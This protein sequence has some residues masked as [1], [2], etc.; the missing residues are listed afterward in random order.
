VTG[1]QGGIIPVKPSQPGAT[2]RPIDFFLEHGALFALSNAEKQLRPAG[3]HTDASGQT[4]TTYHQVHDGVP[5][6]AGVLKVHQDPAGRFIAAN[7]DAFRVPAKLSVRPTLPAAQAEAIARARFALPGLVLEQSELVVVDPGWYGDPS[8]G[9]H[10]AY[11]VVLRDAPGS[12]REAFFIDAHSG[13]MLDRWN[14]LHTARLREVHDAAGSNTLPGPLARAEGDYPTGIADVNKAYDHAGDTY[15]YFLR[16]FDRD[17][18]D[19]EGLPLVITVRSTALPCPNAAWNGQQMVFCSG[20]VTDDIMAHEL[21]HGVTE[22]TANLIYQNQSGQLNEAISDIFGELVDLFNGDAAFPGPPAGP[23]YWPSHPT[24][25]GTDTPNNPRT[26]CSTGATA[27]AD[28]YRWLI[29]EDCSAGVFR[30]MWNPVCYNSPDRANSPLQTCAASDSGG[31]HSG[32]GVANHAFAIMTDGKSFNGQ[33]VTGIGPIKAG[34]VW[35]RALTTYLTVAS[36]FQD[37]YAALNQAAADLVGTDPNDPRTGLPSGDPFTASDAEQVDKALV[38][39][40]M[41]TEGRCGASMAVLDST[42]P[43]QCGPPRTIIFADDFENGSAGWTVSNSNPPTPYDWVQ[44]TEPLPFGRAGTGWF[45]ADAKVGDCMGQ[46]ESAVHT[47]TSPSIALPAGVNHPTVAFTHYIASEPGYDGGNV[48]ISVDN[49]P[50]Q[51]VA[52]SAFEYN[53]YNTSLQSVLAGNTNPLAGEPAWTGAGGEWGTSLISLKSFASGGQAVRLR[54]EFGKDG[55]TG[56]DGWYLDDFEV[57][58]CPPEPPTAFDTSVGTLPDTPITITLAAQDEGQPDPPGQL[59]FIVTSLP[60]HGTLSRTGGAPIESVP[61][62]LPLGENQVVYQPDP[63]YEGND[64]FRFKADDG[65]IPPE[66]G[67]SGEATVTVTVGGPRYLTELFA[68][69]ADA[70]DLD[71][72][73]LMLTPDGSPSFY[74]ACLEPIT[75]LPTDPAGGGPPSFLFE[76]GSDLFFVA[77]GKSV[78]LYGQN[79]SMFWFSSNGFITFDTFDIDDLGMWEESLAGHFGNKRIAALFDDLSPPSG[80]TWSWKELSDRIAITWEN[81]PEYGTSNSNTFQVELYFDGRIQIAWLNI[82][83]RDGLVGLSRGDGLPAEFL[84]QDLSSLRDCRLPQP[85]DFDGD[86]DVDADDYMLFEAC[87]SGPDIPYAGDCSSADFDTDNDVDQSDF[88]VFQ[89]CLSGENNPG[90]PNCAD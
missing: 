15:D 24:G 50:W 68:G 18:L 34:A 16:A 70:F 85:A 26:T 69:P 11:H 40:E 80:G 29:G 25:P 7:G 10:L 38:A 64:S 13:R 84:E 36:D 49:G 44:T 75:E 67:E 77:G 74:D 59:T 42:P 83:A 63:A 82:D 30:D 8:I 43:D 51:L 57:Y 48:K 37:A 66:G 62:S 2:V 65:G 46:D 78:S 32:S 35:Y 33:T 58:G 3:S 22:F 45:V 47:L 76:D 17:S 60:G 90:D 28:G 39:V 9:P 31:V 53:A 41:D 4:H 72:H 12:I 54:F 1:G 89:R 5:V 87:A 81:V 52:S 23:L 61:H 14:M 21:T 19:D 27:F 79:Y 20:M 6:F 55:C 86:R 56:V 71:Y 88:G 73:A